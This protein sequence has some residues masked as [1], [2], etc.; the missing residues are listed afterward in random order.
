MDSAP[1]SPNAFSAMQA[2]I[3]SHIADLIVESARVAKRQRV[4]TISETHVERA[5]DFLVTHSSRSAFRHAGTLGG[6]LLGAA[7]SNLLS[8][9]GTTKM[10]FLSVGVTTFLG[11]L[12]AFGV[13]FH[14][15]K[16]R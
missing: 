12:G 10:S 16:D 15:A 2:A 9:A 11:V 5:S 8:M 14:I 4:D 6:I 13:A 1:F 7:I 3:N